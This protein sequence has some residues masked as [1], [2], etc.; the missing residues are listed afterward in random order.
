MFKFIS[1]LMIHRTAPAVSVS[2][3]FCLTCVLGRFLVTKSEHRVIGLFANQAHPQWTFPFVWTTNIFIWR[4]ATTVWAFQKAVGSP[5][6]WQFRDEGGVWL[7][8]ASGGANL[9]GSL[10]IKSDEASTKLIVAV[11]LLRRTAV[12]SAPEDKLGQTVSAAYQTI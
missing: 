9:Q 6:Q 5:R 3:T 10:E 8:C 11:P 4:F 1:S 7:E 2:S 12:D